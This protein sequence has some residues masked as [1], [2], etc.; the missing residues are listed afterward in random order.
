MRP[1]V[2]RWL[3]DQLVQALGGYDADAGGVGVGAVAGAGIGA[4]EAYAETNGFAAGARP[5]HQ[6]Q[7]ARLESEHNRAPRLVESKML[8]STPSNRSNRLL[9]P[10]RAEAQIG[11]WVNGLALTIVRSQRAPRKLKRQ[12]Q[13]RSLIPDAVH[14]S[15]EALKGSQI[16]L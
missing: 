5:Q 4:V 6:V 8:S 10:R 2:A 13:T 11:T 12:P 14:V 16:H 7:I 9:R 3:A 15:E 1:D